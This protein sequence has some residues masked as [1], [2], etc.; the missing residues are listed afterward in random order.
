MRASILALALCAAAS[1]SPVSVRAQER[2]LDDRIKGSEDEL[3]RLRREIS[4]QRRKIAEI[5]KQEKDVSDYLERLEREE[6]LMKRLLAGLEDKEAM[7]V[8]QIGLL[9][10]DLADNEAVYRHRLEVFSARL[11]EIYKEG[12]RNAWQELLAAE[13]VPDLLQ[14][15]KFLSMIAESDAAMIADVRSRKDRIETQEAELTELLQEVSSSRAEKQSELQKLGENEKKR[16]NTLASLKTRKKDYERNAAE[17]EQAERKLQSLI[18]ELEKQ[19]LEQ[20]KTWGDYGEADFRGL[21][22]RLPHPVEGTVSRGFGRFKHPEYGT[23]TFNTGIDIDTRAGE[24]VRAVARGRIEYAGDLPGYGNC[25]IVNHGGGYYTLYA[26]LARIFVSQGVQVERATL[27][28]ETGR[29][30][31]GGGGTV[32]FEVRESKKALDPAEWLGR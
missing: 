12:T 4:E 13:D 9:R 11:R 8:E 31:G 30:A 2:D 18:E 16:R 3:Q 25:I 29:D 24:P 17:L 6:K 7:I 26:H 14:R 1:I 19:R 21:K 20:A 23:V 32:H 15:Y 22:G 27:I 10:S 28:A 5:E